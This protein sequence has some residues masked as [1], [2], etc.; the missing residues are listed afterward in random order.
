MA[1]PT[2]PLGPMPVA[3]AASPVL[4]HDVKYAAHPA[5]PT[6]AAK[7]AAAI[8]PKT[9]VHRLNCD[10]SDFGDSEELNDQDAANDA[11]LAGLLQATIP[12][13]ASEG[14]DVHSV[15]AAPLSF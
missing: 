14:S 7:Q 10:D 5:E 15:A 1:A 2:T 13:Q 4:V 9:P 11:V 12:H 8:P 6:T 3:S